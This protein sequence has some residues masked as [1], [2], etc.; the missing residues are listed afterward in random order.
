MT[1]MDTFLISLTDWGRQCSDVQ[2]AMNSP[3]Q[4]GVGIHWNKGLCVSV[5]LLLICVCVSLALIQH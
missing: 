5:L 4:L 2:L 1:D 3:V